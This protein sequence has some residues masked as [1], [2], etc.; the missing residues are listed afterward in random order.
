[1]KVVTG[2]LISPDGVTLVVDGHTTP[3]TDSHINYTEIRSLAAARS[4]ASIA[5][6]LDV[7]GSITTFG[8]GEVVVEDG[9]VTYKG[10]PTHGTITDRILAMMDE[11]LAV[12]SMLAFLENL[13]DNPS[14]RAVQEL[15]GFLEVND[16]PF[17]EDGCFL[18]YKM[19]R[20]DFS[21]HRT[22]KFDYSVGAPPATMPRNEVNEDPNQTCS[23]GLHVCAQSYLGMYGG[24]GRT[25]LVKVNPADVVAV[26]TDYDNAKMR[27]CKHETVREVDASTKGNA[28]TSAV[29][30]PEAV[31]DNPALAD[32][33]NVMSFADAMTHFDC[34][35]GA[36]L[37]RLNR[38]VTAKRVYVD[39]TEMVQVVDGSKPVSKADDTVSFEDAM[40]TLAIGRGA[41]RKRL[42]RGSTVERVT[43]DGVDRVRIL[44]SE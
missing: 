17:T 14:Y 26:P 25:I 4:F 22:G 1:M 9:V 6:L 10:T 42:N 11:G 28:L 44:D 35:R 13:M 2:A 27:V 30:V 37:K 29:Y 40:I 20:N 41:L 15:Y 18:A 5:G 34:T 38:G 24:G 12:D 32:D 3:I 39:G 8:R 7:A 33:S 23:A 19:V 31:V 36:L 16:L 21:D 43:V